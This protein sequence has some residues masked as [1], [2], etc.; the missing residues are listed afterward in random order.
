[1]DKCELCGGTGWIRRIEN[2]HE[3]YGR[4]RCYEVDMARRR[5]IQSGISEE[6]L[7]KSFDKFNTKGQPQLINAKNKAMAYA[8]DFAAI[9][10]ERRNSIMFCGQVG[11]GKTHLG[12]AI[13]R[14]LMGQG[15]PVIYMAYR[16]AVTKIKQTIVDDDAYDREMS[17][18]MGARVL[19]IDDLLKGRI[20]EADV[21]IMYEI[22][23]HRYMNGMPIIISTER[24]AE[25]L[26][27]F[28]EATGSRIIEMCRGNIIEL[29]GK[30][31]NH[32]LS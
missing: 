14:E 15:I 20:T 5:M 31:L 10:H 21:N 30:E 19:F 2:G 17:R 32:R 25:G 24:L 18:Y 1:M 12:I 23:N 28:D 29:R 27:E 13:C 26:L 8:R 22:V 3:M 4:C 11:S 9:E 7:D 6:F 16:N